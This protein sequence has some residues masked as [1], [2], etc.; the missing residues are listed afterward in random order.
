MPVAVTLRH[1]QKM[2]RGTWLLLALLGACK[3]NTTSPTAEAPAIPPAAP[4]EPAKPTLAQQLNATTGTLAAVE[5]LRDHF[6]D[7]RD[8]MDPATA[9][10]AVWATT[11]MQWSELQKLPETQR[12]LIMKDSEAERGKRLCASG[13]IVEI[14]ADRSAGKPIYRG[15]LITPSMNVVRFDA[16]GSTGALVER[17]AG[18]ICGV[19]TGK[20]SYSNSGG[21]VTHAVRLVGMFDLPEN[22]APN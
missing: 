16:V 3:G 5:L 10:F 14:A 4:V 19:V 13:S 9:L 7:A 11:R 1:N 20:E 12:A 22:R 6:E 21:G 17:S 18:R 15:G 8:T 2:M